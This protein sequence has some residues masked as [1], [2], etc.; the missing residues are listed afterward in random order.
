MGLQELLWLCQCR[1]GMDRFA[2]SLRSGHRGRVNET[3]GLPSN[4]KPRT[5][6]PVGIDELA[7]KCFLINYTGFRNSQN[8][9]FESE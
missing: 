1:A 8:T 7:M 2:P 3:S 6:I 4:L 5:A 9:I